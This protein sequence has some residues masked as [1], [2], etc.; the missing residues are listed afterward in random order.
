MQILSVQQVCAEFDIKMPT[1]NN[2]V[3][4]AAEVEYSSVDE[5][6]EN[7]PHKMWTRDTTI[8]LITTIEEQ[9]ELDNF[10]KDLKKNLWLKIAKQCS[11]KF[12]DVGRKNTEQNVKSKTTEQHKGEKQSEEHMLC[13]SSFSRKHKERNNALVQR[14]NEKMARMD[15]FND[16]FDQMV[17]KMPAPP[18]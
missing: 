8:F 3:S 13:E 2:E 1:C 12:K 15:R 5:S 9:Y 4:N 17:K 10:D 18:Q 16:L 7:T 11:E 14:H 6:D